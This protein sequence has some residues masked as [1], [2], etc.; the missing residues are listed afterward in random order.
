M[1]S[2]V[3][4]HWFL[5]TY[6]DSR[7]IMSG[8]HGSGHETG[9]REGTLDYLTQMA[10]AAESQGMESML[11]P[12]G[13]SCEDAWVAAAALIPQTKRLKFLI[14]IR[15]GLVS[16]TIIAQQ[17]ATF[18]NLSGNRLLLNVVVGGED[19][20]Q[21]A[22]GDESTKEE[23]YRR[24]GEVLQ[25]TDQLWNSAE[26]ITFR[27]E[28][29]S[30]ENAALRVRPE[31]SP[32]I[33]FGGSSQPGIEVAA[34]RADVYLTWGEPPAQAKAK[35][36]RVAAL[37]QTE[38]RELEY[39]IRFH[40]IARPTSAEAWAA[41]QG[42][43]DSIDPAEVKRIQDGLARS[44]SEGQRRMS[45]LHQQGNGYQAGT[46]AH[47]LEIAPNLWAGV[48]LIRGGA[49]TALVGSYDEVAQR[50]AEYRE[51]GFEHFILSG[52]PNLEETFQVGEGVVPALQRL[53][54]DVANR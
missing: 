13:L 2:H 46:D 16:P 52:Y 33:F 44:Q 19:H 6:G 11:V 29:T 32:Q 27:G 5:P 53:G 9:E 48:G 30:V 22:F 40:I 21:R 3:T 31:V 26:E 20:E 47:E 4:L 17:A 39:G 25:I 28:H 23:R 8:G 54:V 14:A 12:T 7:A 49:G 51:V 10:L 37:A 1:N 35:I 15:P 42:L 50:I 18:Q 38:H 36:D 24:A 41:A 43:L 34:Q 45:E